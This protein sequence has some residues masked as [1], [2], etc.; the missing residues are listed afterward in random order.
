MLHSYLYYVLLSVL[1]LLKDNCLMYSF[2]S[3]FPVTNSVAFDY[4]L[5][6]LLLMLSWMQL[7][8]QYYMDNCIHA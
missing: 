5:T 1:A 7:S 6:L 8:K 3:M 4:A 2:R